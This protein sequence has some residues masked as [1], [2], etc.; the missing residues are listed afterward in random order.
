M[1]MCMGRVATSTD[2]Q[3]GAASAVFVNQVEDK[4]EYEAE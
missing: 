3:W 2:R 4:G 1:A